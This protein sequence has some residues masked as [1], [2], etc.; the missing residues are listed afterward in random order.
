MADEPAY[1]VSGAAVLGLLRV[2]RP[3]AAAPLLSE[4]G[5]AGL[6][7]ADPETRVPQAAYNQLWERVTAES[8][9][10]ELGLHL[11]ERLDLD[12]FHVVGHLAS[13]SP[14]LGAALERIARYSRILHDAGRV[15]V[16]QV[17]DEAIIYPGCRGLRH[18]VPRG[19]AESSAASIVVLGRRLTRSTFAPRAVEFRHAEPRRT[20][21]HRRILGVRPSFGHAENR[22]VVDRS[23]LAL[24]IQ[25]EGGGLLRYLDAYA[26]ELLAKLPPDEE[27]FAAKVLRLILGSFGGAEV[28]AGTIAKRLGLHPRTLQRRLEALGTSFQSL[29]D[30]ARRSLAERYLTEDGLAVQ[31]I[32]FLLG[33]ADPSNFHRAFRRWTGQTPAQFRGA[34]RGGSASLGSSSDGSV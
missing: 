26:E 8:G 31:E 1:S 12:A 25:A 22:L 10:P 3:E 32:A 13:R 24:P 14:T 20:E 15:E 18:A 33:Y 28:D 4:C 6:A 11:A 7:L 23:V 29:Y 9:D 16:E 27:D 2:L 17:G 19:V 34:R 21:E 5:L 30:E